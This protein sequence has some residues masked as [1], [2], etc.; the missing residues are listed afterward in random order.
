MTRPSRKNR[1]VK[2]SINRVKREATGVYNKIAEI[3]AKTGVQS[4]RFYGIE[5]DPYH[6]GFERVPLDEQDRQMVVF[7]AKSG[8]G[9]NMDLAGS[10][11]KPNSKKVGGKTHGTLAARKPIVTRK[12]NSPKL[13]FIRGESV[14]NAKGQRVLGPKR[15]AELQRAMKNYERRTKAKIKKHYGE[16]TPESIEKYRRMMKDRTVIVSF[17]REQIK[18]VKAYNTLIKFLNRDKTKEFKAELTKDRREWLT[19]TLEVAYELSP[20]EN[21]ELFDTINSM[22]AD[23]ILAWATQNPQFVAKL[24]YHYEEQWD[25]ETHNDWVEI[26]NELIDTLQPYTKSAIPKVA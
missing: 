21:P 22:T 12:P 5:G 25:S 9:P 1:S 15:E 7:K 23:Q 13:V 2:S 16:V 24:F 20:E 19:K 26:V 8:I 18:N 10:Y 3:S 14:V 6:E 11:R 17:D 4:G